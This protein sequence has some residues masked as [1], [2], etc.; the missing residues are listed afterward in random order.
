MPWSF[1]PCCRHFSLLPV[2]GGGTSE[3]FC[4]FPVREGDCLIGDRGYAKSDGVAS[5]VD[6]GGHVIV[7]HNPAQM[8]LY[9]ADGSRFELRAALSEW[10][11]E[12]QQT[13]WPSYVRHGEGKLISGRLI[14]VRRSNEAMRREVKK[15]RH[16]ASRKQS[17]L[18]QRSL[19]FAKY[20]LVFT[21]L[22]A[23]RY[24]D[25]FCLEWYRLRWQIELIFKRL[26]SLAGLGHLPKHDPDS[27]QAW[28]YAKL[29]TGLL[30]EKLIRYG[31]SISPWGYKLG[32]KA[33]QSVA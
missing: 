17:V 14:V 6:R 15:L 18:Q 28:L 3:S 31:E 10:P 4:R 11:E 32:S 29:F 26:K 9:H 2:D 19:E 1:Q 12:Q 24:D 23:D 5:V 20:I 7:R 33:P 22:P 8:K 25:D 27:S 30:A 21:T 13:A 16:R